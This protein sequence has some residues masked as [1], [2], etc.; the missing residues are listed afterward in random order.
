MAQKA[1]AALWHMWHAHGSYGFRMP[2]LPVSIRT[3]FGGFRNDPSRAGIG[4]K[5]PWIAVDK[6]GKRFMNEWPRAAADTPLR[7]LDAYDFDL[8]EFLAT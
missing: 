6:F 2:G 1:G 4:R 5:M 3:P 7:D 8:L